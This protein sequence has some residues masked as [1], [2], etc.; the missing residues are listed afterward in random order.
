MITDATVRTQFLSSFRDAVPRTPYSGSGRRHEGP[1]GNKSARRRSLEPPAVSRGEEAAVPLTG[2]V[3]IGYAELTLLAIVCRHPGFFEE[4]EEEIGV[5]VFSDDDRDRLRQALIGLLSGHHAKTV[6]QL[7][8]TLPDEA[9]RV[10]FDAVL[11]DPFIRRHRLISATA[12]MNQV[13]ATWREN[14]NLLRRLLDAA[15]PPPVKTNDISDANLMR[16]FAHKRATLDEQA[17]EQAG[18]LD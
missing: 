11:G 5:F 13:R 17:R 18:D 8:A 12:A 9:L 1:G 15:E 14:A 16:P 7:R 6:A 10:T 3:G 2:G 4:V